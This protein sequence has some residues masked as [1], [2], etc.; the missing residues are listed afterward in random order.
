MTSQY[1]VTEIP[2]DVTIQFS[3]ITRY[4]AAQCRAVYLYLYRVGLG[5]P[6]TP[7]PPGSCHPPCIGRGGPRAPSRDH[8]RPA[9]PVRPCIYIYIC[10]YIPITPLFL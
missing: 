7:S 9:G 5:D 3:I 8:S 1:D 2:N 10:V 6:C 4:K